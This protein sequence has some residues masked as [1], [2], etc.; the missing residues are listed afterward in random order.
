[1]AGHRR[2]DERAMEATEDNSVILKVI[3][4]R[5]VPYWGSVRQSKWHVPLWGHVD[6]IDMLCGVTRP[7]FP[8]AEKEIEV[9]VVSIKEQEPTCLRCRALLYGKENN[10]H[11]GR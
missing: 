7:E 4:W 8:T 10:G 5:T 3:R 9:D 11:A 1:M 2:I 6:G